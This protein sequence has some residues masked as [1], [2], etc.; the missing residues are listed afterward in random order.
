[1]TGYFIR[2]CRHVDLDPAPLLRQLAAERAKR[3]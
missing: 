3:E 1:V 2:L